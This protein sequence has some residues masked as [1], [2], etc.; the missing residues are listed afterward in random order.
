MAVQAGQQPRIWLQGLSCKAPNHATPNHVGTADEANPTTPNHGGTA[1]EANPTTPN[2][3][4][5]A[6]EANPTTPNHAQP[7]PLPATPMLS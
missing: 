2:H 5:T 7:A 6:D 1:D 4:G 3:V